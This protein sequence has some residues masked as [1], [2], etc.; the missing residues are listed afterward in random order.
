M[1]LSC[2]NVDVHCFASFFKSTRS[3][4]CSHDVGHQYYECSQTHHQKVS[5]SVVYVMSCVYVKQSV[6]VGGSW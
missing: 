1:I 4:K 2:N 5:E 6:L 3:V